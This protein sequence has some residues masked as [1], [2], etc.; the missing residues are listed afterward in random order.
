MTYTYKEYKEAQKIVR[1]F[2][3]EKTRIFVERTNRRYKT[4]NDKDRLWIQRQMLSD[5]RNEFRKLNEK[6]AF[7]SNHQKHGLDF[8]IC[9]AEE[10]L[11]YNR[12]AIKYK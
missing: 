1:T 7:A 2:E 6:N 10:N 12:K 5:M 11:L 8:K 9:Q 4:D 3:S